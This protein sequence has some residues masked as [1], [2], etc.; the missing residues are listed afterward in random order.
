MDA[1]TATEPALEPARIAQSEGETPA[2]APVPAEIP[3]RQDQGTASVWRVLEIVAAIFGLIF[4]AA[5]LFKWK[6]SKG[7]HPGNTPSA[8]D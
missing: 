8:R 5:M 7:I 2:A 1:T 6:L 4:L 3:Q